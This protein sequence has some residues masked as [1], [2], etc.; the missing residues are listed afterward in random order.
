MGAVPE[1]AACFRRAIDG[2]SASDGAYVQL[3]RLLQQSGRPAERRLALKLYAARQGYDLKRSKLEHQSQNDMGN[4]QLQ[5][6][7]GNLLLSSGRAANAFPHLL[8]AASVRPG[9]K[10]AQRR[11]ADACAL[12]D[13]DDL[14][15]QAERAAS[16]AH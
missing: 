2:E 1:A 13:Y 10:A 3:A 8:R 14:R 11:L 7:M 4:A 12:L 5:F 6:E 9:W 15:E 16:A